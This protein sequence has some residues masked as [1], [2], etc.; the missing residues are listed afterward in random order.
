[1]KFK[2]NVLVILAVLLMTSC[3]KDDPVVNLAESVQGSYIGYSIADFKYTTIPITTSDVTVALTANADGTSNVLF[4]A[5]R[6]GTFTIPHA[7]VSIKGD[8]YTLKGVGKTIM[9]MTEE[10]KK[11]YDCTVDGTISKDKKTTTFLFEAPS[12]MG[13]LK[14]TFNLGN[15]PAEDLVAGVYKG[16]LAL[17]VAGS[18]LDPVKDSQVT[19][20]KQAEGKVEVTLAGFAGMGSMKLEDIVIADVS[21]TETKKG[22]YTLSGK[23]DTQ[24][25]KFHITGKIEGGIEKESAAI[26]FTIKPGAM[27]MDIT[28]VFNGKK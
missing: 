22:S 18:T 6:F 23:V 9:G 19:I 14:I 20:K 11:E 13:G 2:I 7:A 21:I 28:A 3:S 10:S 16:E 15:A 25:G 12:V 1:M 17:S 24:S 4:T 27:P 5:G 26:T 8:T